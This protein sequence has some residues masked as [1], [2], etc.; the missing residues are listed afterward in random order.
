MRIGTWNLEGKWSDDHARLLGELACDVWLLTENVPLARPDGY[1]LHLTVD[2]MGEKKYWAGIASRWPIDPLPDPDVASA[3]GQISGVRFCSS[4]LPWKQ[5]GQYSPWGGG[6]HG[7][8]MAE[9]LG[10]LRPVLAEPPVVWGGD[11]NQPLSGNIQ[12][13][14]RDAQRVLLGA[15]DAAGLVVPTQL[16]PGRPAGQQSIDHIAVPA[17]WEVVD[18][19][20]VAVTPSLSDHDAY[21]IEVVAPGSTAPSHT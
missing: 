16:L 1:D 19:G 13:F 2:R 17:S 14:T 20:H 4:V 10:R 3:L 15:V 9:V 11:W 12:G 21:W 8:E 18:A 7:R 6:S 5:A